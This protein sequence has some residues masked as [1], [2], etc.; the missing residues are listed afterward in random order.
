M[1]PHLFFLGV[2]GLKN[3]SILDEILQYETIL[4]IWWDKFIPYIITNY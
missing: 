2:F 4:Q 3:Q 1:S